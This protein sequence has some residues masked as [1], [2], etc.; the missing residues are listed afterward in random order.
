MSTSIINGIDVNS[1]KSFANDVA[2]GSHKGIVKFEVATRWAG[3]TRSE[4]QVRSWQMGGR[5]LEKAFTILIDEPKEL[6]GENAAANPQEMLMAAFNACMIVGYAAG[7]SLRGITL[8]RLEIQTTGSL[9]LRGFLG[10]DSSVKPGYDEIEYTVII[11]GNG[12]PED[13]QAIHETVMATSPNRWN[14][15]N[16]IRL[17]STLEIE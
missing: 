4:T 10:L 15:A 14:I 8:E 16:P 1:L 12:T 3:R 9:D 7:C 11:K 5:K 17:K 6:L 2:Q 13:F